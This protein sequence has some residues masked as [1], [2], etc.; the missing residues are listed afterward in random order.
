MSLTQVP[1]SPLGAPKPVPV[2]VVPNL[3]RAP[4]E[5][6]IQAVPAPRSV[7]AASTGSSA[8][9]KTTLVDTLSVPDAEI[10]LCGWLLGITQERMP[11]AV[12]LFSQLEDTAFSHPVYRA[13]WSLARPFIARR[14]VP[15]VSALVDAAERKK[16]NVG[17]AEHLAQLIA[18]PLAAS[19]DADRL[20]Q[21]AALV[22]EYALRRRLDSALRARLQELPTCESITQVIESLQNEARALEFMIQTGQ[23]SGPSHISEPVGDVLEKIFDKEQ[24]ATNVVPTG[25]LG[26]DENLTGGGLSDEQL[27]LIAGR[28][29]M[30]KTALAHDFA[31][32]VSL[33]TAGVRRHVLFFSGEMTRHELAWRG[34]SKETGYSV[35]ELRDADE[36][37]AVLGET[38]A[39]VIP[40]FAPY[41]ADGEPGQLNGSTL[42]IDD[43][44]GMTPSYI[45]ATAEQFVAEH[46]PSLIVVDYLQLIA[47]Y[48][49]GGAAR[50]ATTASIVGGF[51]TQL[52]LLARRLHCPVVALAQLNRELEKRANKR[53]IISD[54]RDSGNLEQDADIIIFLYRDWIYN[55]QADPYAAEAI[56]AKQRSGAIATV[57]LTFEAALARYR[58][59]MPA[60]FD[61]RRPAHAA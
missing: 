7:S 61:A 34:L 47:S 21:D 57:P 26:L 4:V 22:S 6:K 12:T 15:G 8:L 2:A 28:P 58:D 24:L 45:T 16:L 30:G 51:S 60:G 17:G 39:A 1:V 35:Q 10:E 54:L 25:L 33:N 38:L 53:P 44:S 14:E 19:A 37:D 9:P 3:R 55:D 41:K 59:V 31:R 36:R 40:R 46:G 32:N 52:K 56:I 20:R 5:K 29:G 49:A 13:I 23:K 48:G 27:I 43:S 11:I 18:D 42:Y 50:D